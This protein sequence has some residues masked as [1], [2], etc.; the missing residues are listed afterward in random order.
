MNER[1]IR[2]EA[3]KRLEL[4]SRSSIVGG[5][6]KAAVEEIKRLDGLINNAHTDDFLSS[7]ALEAAHQRERW[8]AEDDRG[9]TDPDWFWL[10][11]YL[12]GKALTKPDKKVHHIITTAATCLNWHAHVTGASTTMRP[13]TDREG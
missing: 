13:G 12:A 5:D 8:P 4:L 2:S 1:F 3:F 6:I 9:K 11:G 7:V 10:L